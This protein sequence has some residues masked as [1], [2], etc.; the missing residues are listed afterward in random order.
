MPTRSTE[1]L[2]DYFRGQAIELRRIATY[3]AHLAPRIRELADE[4]ER[5]AE[6]VA[7]ERNDASARGDRLPR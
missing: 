3:Q 7:W 2:V 1:E 5:I 6:R 4:L